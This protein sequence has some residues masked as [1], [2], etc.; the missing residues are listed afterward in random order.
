MSE[1]LQLL[2]EERLRTLLAA[3]D[4]G[5]DAAEEI[6][7]RAVARFLRAELLNGAATAEAWRKR[8]A[9]ACAASENEDAVDEAIVAAVLEAGSQAAAVATSDV[10]RDLAIAAYDRIAL[11]YYISAFGAAA[12]IAAKSGRVELAEDLRQ[13]RYEAGQHSEAHE[14]LTRSLLDLA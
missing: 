13:C 4:A 14:K 7:R 11:G 2:L 8:L 6:D 3:C 10:A 9:R 12:V 5:A 1:P